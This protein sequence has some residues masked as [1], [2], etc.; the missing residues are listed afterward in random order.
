MNKSQ[1]FEK[2]GGM[3]VHS[4]EDNPDF[5]DYLFLHPEETQLLQDQYVND[6][7]QVVSIHETEDEQDFVDMSQPCD[8][9]SQPYKY[10]YF[11][12]KRPLL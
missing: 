3:L 1:F 9:G 4:A 2:Y 10:G 8:F 5:G 11:V 12:I 7:H 6:Q